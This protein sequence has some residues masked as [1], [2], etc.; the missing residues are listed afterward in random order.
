MKTIKLNKNRWIIIPLFFGIFYLLF[1]ELYVRKSQNYTMIQQITFITI[2]LGE[3]IYIM[4]LVKHKANMLQMLIC[5]SI[6]IL[7]WDLHI[8]CGNMKNENGI[9]FLIS[10][11]V[12]HLLFVI[13]LVSVI[14]EKRKISWHIYIKNNYFVI[15]ISVAV[16]ILS[17]FS[18]D[19]WLSSG[20]FDYYSNLD[21]IVNRW[22]FSNTP[23]DRLKL[24]GHSSQAYSMLLSIGGYLTVKNSLIGARVIQL[25]MAC[26]TIFCQSK[27]IEK[28]FCNI[29]SYIKKILLVTFAFSPLFFGLIQEIN[30]DYA[31]F[32]FFVWM[33]CCRL[34][35]LNDLE[36]FCM[37]LLVFSKETGV[38]IYL[39]YLLGTFLNDLI[40]LEK[41]NFKNIIK[42]IFS[43]RYIM[44]CL[45]GYM[46]LLFMRISSANIWG[47]A[48]QGE[49]S[50]INV[51]GFNFDYIVFKIK[52]LL[53]PNFGW[54]CY[55]FFV[56][57]LIIYIINGII[58]QKK[59]F[60]KFNKSFYFAFVCS[61]VAYLLMDVLYITFTNYRYG[62]ICVF[63]SNICLGL[64]ISLIYKLNVNKRFLMILDIFVIYTM[65]IIGMSNFYTIDKVFKCSKYTYNVGKEYMIGAQMFYI[66]P[67]GEMVTNES[68]GGFATVGMVYNKEYQQL[69]KLINKFL[70]DINYSKNDLIIVP[71]THSEYASY[72][73]FFG[74]SEENGL[75]NI[76]WNSKTKKLNINHTNIKNLY[77]KEYEK[78]NIAT[79]K[80]KEDFLKIKN[81]Y[82]NIYVMELP[83]NKENGFQYRTMALSKKSYSGYTYTINMYKL[84]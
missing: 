74:R 50:S 24:C 22:D 29:P 57:V 45:P 53:S 42:L 11:F 61:F 23:I 52:Q 30:T 66:G 70:D 13:C 4:R 27:I 55:L 63:F 14:T 49:A 75:E 78:M 68:V 20:A 40:I 21:A 32:C 2:L 79:F 38:V 59:V 12:I 62:I 48:T 36:I 84:K 83:Y 72:S 67:N 16:F 9:L 51:F 81:D 82:K 6:L 46:Y 56:I 34:Y 71:Y 37:F 47:T 76:Y 5:N 18:I 39:G 73:N 15:I 28:V 41:T 69:G 60:C 7:F 33:F 64:G 65:I 25:L 26:L 3:Y 58:K 1:A 54:L 31:M 19:A 44:Y 43:K 17:I 77:K 8:L 35:C 10:T 80:N